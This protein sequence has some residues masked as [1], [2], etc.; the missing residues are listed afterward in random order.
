MH[1]KFMKM[2]KMI[3]LLAQKI[4]TGEADITMVIHDGP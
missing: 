3:C 1:A 4:L 2:N